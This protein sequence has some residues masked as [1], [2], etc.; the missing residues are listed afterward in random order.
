[1]GELIGCQ[2]LLAGAEAA[3]FPARLADS[4]TC[5]SVK[6]GKI[7]VVWEC[8][9]CVRFRDEFAVEKARLLSH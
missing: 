1:L 4:W 2:D 7:N 3:E 8:W 9:V 6:G 5:K